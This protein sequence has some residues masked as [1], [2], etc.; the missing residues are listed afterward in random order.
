M[1]K[2]AIFFL[3]TLCS[4]AIFGQKDSIRFYYEAGG[5]LVSAYVSH[6]RYCG[7]LSLQPKV[8][9]GYM[10]KKTCFRF[11]MWG[12]VGA[13]DW[14]FSS[15]K[16]SYT[17]SEKTFFV[18]ELNISPSFGFFGANIG[19]TYYYYFDGSGFFDFRNV[20]PYDP[21]PNST[22]IEVWGQYDFETLLHFPLLFKWQT[23]VGG[24]DGY[25]DSNG[26]F[27]RAF[28]TNVSFQYTFSLPH[29]IYLKLG[30]EFSP[31]KSLYTDYDKNFSV[32]CISARLEKKWKKKTTTFV[33]F[34]QG[35]I[36]T[37]NLNKE[38]AFINAAGLTK[39]NQKLNGIIGL[40][41]WF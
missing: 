25:Y 16:P 29:L 26:N 8:C 13:S 38:T 39:F 27:T 33:L 12:S 15:L 18:P 41:I 32:N 36:N 10:G 11:E 2:T 34:A 7:G 14:K 6:G 35:F 31:W 37:C 9:L 1:K 22:Q 21:K 17:G 4:T 40:G 5:E 30:L 28:S 23:I 24:F 20:S 3:L 19:F